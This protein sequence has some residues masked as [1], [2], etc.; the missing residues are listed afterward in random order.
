MAPPRPPAQSPP[1]PT[2]DDL[3]RPRV[4]GLFALFCACAGAFQMAILCLGLFSFWLSTDPFRSVH[5]ASI[6]A[7][8]M[9]LYG[10]GWLLVV[11]S[12]P[13]A[14]AFFVAPIL[15][16]RPWAWRYA[17]AMIGIGSV[18]PFFF[19]AVPVSRQWGSAEVLTWYGLPASDPEDSPA[20]PAVSQATPPQATPGAKPV[21]AVPLASLPPLPPSAPSPEPPIKPGDP[22][23]IA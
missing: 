11:M 23:T 2:P 22:P 17:M 8:A 4:F 16:R 3:S 13:L 18:G 10:A 1:P 9:F 7:M 5:G 19:L 14:L 21:Q 15:P 20:S 6:G 12:V